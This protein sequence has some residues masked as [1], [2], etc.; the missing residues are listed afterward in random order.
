MKEIMFFLT[1]EMKLLLDKAKK[2]ER[3]LNCSQEEIIRKLIEAGWNTIKI[4]QPPAH[5]NAIRKGEI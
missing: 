4:N 2:K 5:N 1:P 3:F